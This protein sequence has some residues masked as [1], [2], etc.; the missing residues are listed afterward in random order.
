[1]TAVG[2]TMSRELHRNAVMAIVLAIGGIL[3]YLAFVFRSQHSV[4]SPWAF[5][6]IAVLAVVHD[7]LIATGVFAAYSRWSGATADSLFITAILTTDIHI[8]I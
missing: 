6:V 8:I 3:I 5:G 2:P 7:V 4:I 1:M